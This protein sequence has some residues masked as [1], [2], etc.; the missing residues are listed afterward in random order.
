M[1]W[2]SGLDRIYFVQG[3]S[4][5]FIGVI[6]AGLRWRWQEGPTES[7]DG[8]HVIVIHR[9]RSVS[10]SQVSSPPLRACQLSTK[11]GR[12]AGGQRQSARPWMGPTALKICRGTPPSAAGSRIPAKQIWTISPAIRPPFP[13][14]PFPIRECFAA[15]MIGPT[16]RSSAPN[17]RYASVGR[18]VGRSFAVTSEGPRRTHPIPG[19]TEKSRPSVSW[20]LGATWNGR[21]A[22]RRTALWTPWSKWGRGGAWR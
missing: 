18:S 14:P 6:V 11:E 10:V 1:N 9:A 13:D 4:R 17:L 22:S 3:T 7:A 16:S 20:I 21:P 12:K 5:T 15:A 8:S 19:V 2:I